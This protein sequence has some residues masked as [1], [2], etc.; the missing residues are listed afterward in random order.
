MHTHG[1]GHEGGLGREGRG[2]LSELPRRYLLRVLFLRLAK[3]SAP[4]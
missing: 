3:G 2:G 4:W 1:A